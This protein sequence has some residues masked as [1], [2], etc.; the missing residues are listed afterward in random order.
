MIEAFSKYE[1][2][3]RKINSAINKHELEHGNGE[4]AL[5]FS[6]A[7]SCLNKGAF[8]VD[9]IYEMVSRVVNKKE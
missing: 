4:L 2:L 9:Q 7:Y 6:T 8:S 1:I 5:A 3:Y